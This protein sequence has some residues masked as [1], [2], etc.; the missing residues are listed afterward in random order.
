MKKRK[1]EPDPR[2][3][4]FMLG[5]AGAKRAADHAGE[6]WQAAAYR[7]FAE[8]AKR[9]HWFTCED[10]REANPNLPRPPDQ[11]AWGQIALSARRN[12]LVVMGPWVTARS[13]IVHG[14]AVRSWRSAAAVEKEK[15]DA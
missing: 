14:N 13:R 9:G 6:D 11:R 10:V 12:G 3:L 2:Q 8:Y 1:K 4:G 5:A 7:A 15:A